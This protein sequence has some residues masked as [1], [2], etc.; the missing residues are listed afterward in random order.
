[1]K[2]KGTNPGGAGPTGGDAEMQALS[3]ELASAMQG[4][5]SA[6]KTVT[7][8]PMVRHV[9]PPDHFSA[10]VA[11]AVHGE[12]TPSSV[13]PRVRSAQG[14]PVHQILASKGFMGNIASPDDPLFAWDGKADTSLDEISTREL[15][16]YYDRSMA[17]LHGAMGRMDF[18]RK[19]GHWYERYREDLR[20]SHDVDYDYSRSSTEYSDRNHYADMEADRMAADLSFSSSYSDDDYY[21]NN[22]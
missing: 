1:M 8:A 20:G 21:R 3:K 11:K 15:L 6:V 4:L 19:E 2:I 22:R 17:A 7:S 10:A 16:G 5:Q 18:D 14:V 13:A 9:S 12:A